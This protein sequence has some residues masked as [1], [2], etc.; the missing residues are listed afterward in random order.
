M[1]KPL[2]GR[3]SA[4]PPEWDASVPGGAQTPH[5]RAIADPREREVERHL[6]RAG[7]PEL[8]RRR[9]RWILWA[10]AILV[11]FIGFCY[12][13]PLWENRSLEEWQRVALNAVGVGLLTA[14]LL[15]VVNGLAL[16]RPR[17]WGVRAIGWIVIALLTASVLTFAALTAI[18]GLGDGR[19]TGLKS[20]NFTLAL[21]AT[22]AAGVA[23]LG[24]FSLVRAVLVSAVRV[25]IRDIPTSMK[26]APEMLFLVAFVIILG[27]VW[28][29]LGALTGWRVEVLLLGCVLLATVA[30]AARLGDE[31]RGL[32]NVD[33]AVALAAAGR[34]PAFASLVRGRL[35]DG[36]AARTLRGRAR[37]NAV[38][39]V[40]LPLTV[41]LIVAAAALTLLLF[42]IGMVLMDSALAGAVPAGVP[43]PVAAAKV[44]ALLSA[45]AAVAY[46]VGDRGEVITAMARQRIVE[47]QPALGLWSLYYAGE[48]TAG[49]PT[50]PAPAR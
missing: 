17:H 19:Y 39:L 1:A 29:G 38:L 4:A 50:A 40:V 31:L 14:L 9:T 20:G 33:A 12:V 26:A 36:A 10:A 25:G 16:S 6:R 43:S 28:R 37:W 44:A 41:R 23:V 22:L 5:G 11:L 13:A 46:A 8:C 18:G 47:L 42:V 30:I 49:A 15:T 32:V 21:L 48:Q 35:G 34:D 24:G 3:S 27:D 2:S 45:L 7:L